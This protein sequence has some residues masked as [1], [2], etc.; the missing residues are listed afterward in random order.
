MT[1]YDYV[2]LRLRATDQLAALATVRS[3]LVEWF[4]AH[5]PRVGNIRPTTWLVL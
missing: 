2:F 5:R 1:D 3:E 4:A